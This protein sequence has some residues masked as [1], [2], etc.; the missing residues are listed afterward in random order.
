VT[1]HAVGLSNHACD[2]ADGCAIDF[3]ALVSEER[4]LLPVYVDW[5]WISLDGRVLQHDGHDPLRTLEQ[6]RRGP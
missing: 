5:V 3:G 4:L 2:K 1:D 6:G